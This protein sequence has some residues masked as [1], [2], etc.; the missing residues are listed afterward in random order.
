MPKFG[1]PQHD[2]MY[3]TTCRLAMAD[4]LGRGHL[5]KQHYKWKAISISNYARQTGELSFS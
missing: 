2:A 5:S 4:S 1:V 3:Q